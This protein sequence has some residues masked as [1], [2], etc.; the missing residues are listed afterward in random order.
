MCD[1]VHAVLVERVEA[2]VARDQ[3]TVALARVFGA[4]ADWPSLDE[5]LARLDEL[6]AA[7]PVERDPEEVRLRA[8]LG[9][10][11]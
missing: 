4:K 10:R 1:V 2:S 8:V 11:R 6:L 5:R 9:L 7:E 3:Q